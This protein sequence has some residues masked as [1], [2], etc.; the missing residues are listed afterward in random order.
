MYFSGTSGAETQRAGPVEGGNT[1]RRDALT[2]GSRNVLLW[3]VVGVLTT[4]ATAGNLEPPGPPAP[5]MKDLD[6]VE[7]RKAIRNLGVGMPIVISISGSYY[8]AEDIQA[9]PGQ[10]GIEIDVDNVTL[11]LNGFTLYGDLD[12]GSMDGIHITDDRQNIKILNGVIRSFQGDG[13][14]AED[15]TGSTNVHVEGVTTYLNGGVGMHLDNNA[16]VIGCAAIDN[17]NDGVRVDSG[18]TIVHSVAWSNGGDGFS[19]DRST[20][21]NCTA[22]G[23]TSNGIQADDSLVRG[24]TAIQNGGTNILIDGGIAI[25]NHDVDPN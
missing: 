7:P 16:T 18:S 14:D 22:N 9:L 20:I 3:T 24:N 17:A 2:R 21:T 13:I 5:T 12:V 25:D 11:D 15:L 10:H 1:M 23:N 19:L 6:D 4:L 8:L